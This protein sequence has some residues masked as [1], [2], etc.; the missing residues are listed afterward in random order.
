MFDL[1]ILVV[2]VFGKM[3]VIVMLNADDFDKVLCGI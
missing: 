1:Q 2:V 3:N